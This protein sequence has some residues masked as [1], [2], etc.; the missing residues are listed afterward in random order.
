MKIIECKKAVTTCPNCGNPVSDNI[1]RDWEDEKVNCFI[2]AELD[3]KN[4]VL[5]YTIICMNDGEQ[6]D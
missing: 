6:N 2:S 1:L 4:K 3:N 5:N